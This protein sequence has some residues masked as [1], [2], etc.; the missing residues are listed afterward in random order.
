[1]KSFNDWYLFDLNHENSSYSLVMDYIRNHDLN[2]SLAIALLQV[3]YSIF[4]V[5]KV[6]STMIVLRDLIKRSKL[7][8]LSGNSFT[9]ING[10]IFLGRVIT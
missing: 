2:K 4:E 1:M 9:A 6:T 10:D 5:I 7:Q 3:N 8:L